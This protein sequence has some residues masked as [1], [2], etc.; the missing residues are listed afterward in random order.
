[1]GSPYFYGYNIV[2]S[3]FIIQA[4]SIGAMFTYGVFFNEFQTEFGWSRA[5][6]SGASSFAFLIMGAVGVLAGRLND[7]IGPRVIVTASSI[8]LGIGYL[9]MSR[10]A[11][12][13]HLYLLY[14]LLVGIGFSTHDVITLSTVARWFVKRRGIITGIV[15]AGTG[16]GQ[17][18]VPLVVTATI[19]AFGW[20]TS[21]L[22]IGA[23]GLIML[24]AAAQ[25]LRR[26]PLEM[27]LL[28][29]GNGQ[30]SPETNTG[31]VEI[32]VTLALASRTTQFWIMCVA[33]F[34]ILFCLLTMIVHIVPHAVDLGLSSAVAAGVLST[35]GGVS[36]VGRLVMGAVND[37]V[38]GKRSL[39]ICFVVLLVG[40]VWLQWADRA[41]MLFLFG[42]I[43]G[44]AHGGFF[45]VVSPT[46]AELFGTGSHGLLFGVILF[47]GTIGGAIGPLSAGWIYDLT[48]SY[49][50]LFLLL[51]GVSIVGF[52]FI[53]LLR[54]IKGGMGHLLKSE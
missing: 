37:R 23:A 40:L 3:C 49:S 38:G 5:M 11:E 16:F 35:I 26:D 54:P 29:D 6:V 4:I 9:L 13:W 17:L 33:E 53:L 45:T 20:R 27:G 18:F 47:W 52:A 22:I 36:M 24:S 34:T 30:A 44:F 46:V 39:V 31:S 14:G 21:Y 2:A 12:L 32:G 51:T 28:P 41:W 7:K 48:G 1:M 10:L 25:V 43:Y 8:S 19:S 42:A 50:I 15:K